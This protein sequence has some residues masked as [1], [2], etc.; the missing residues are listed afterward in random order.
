[1]NDPF[2]HPDFDHEIARAADLPP[3]DPDARAAILSATTRHV[4]RRRYIRHM[5]QAAALI[6]AFISGAILMPRAATSPTE[7][8]QMA[9]T[10]NPIAP[11]LEPA[12]PETTLPI[13]NDPEAFAMVYDNATP[14][15]RLDLLK[16]AGD[17]ALNVESDIRTAIDYYKLWIDLADEAARTQYNRN[18]TWL[19][20]SLKHYK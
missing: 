16:A 13:Y 8:Q 20:A 9:A 11:V 19:L 18:D 3:L 7:P 15:E 17:Y 2:D 14:G 6:A 4:R 1:M 5:W 10:E 12:P